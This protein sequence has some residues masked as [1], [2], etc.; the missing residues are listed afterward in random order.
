MN[1]YVGRLIQLFSM[2]SVIAQVLFLLFPSYIPNTFFLSIF[3]ASCG[4]AIVLLNQILY[5]ATTSPLFILSAHLSHFIPLVM[6]YYLGYNNEW[7]AYY[8]LCAVVIYIIVFT[9]QKILCIYSDMQAF[10]E[11]RK[12][13]NEQDRTA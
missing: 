10:L 3:T 5:P 6:H 1:L 12:D 2:Q 4:T 7:N 8:V 9:P 11:K 13:C